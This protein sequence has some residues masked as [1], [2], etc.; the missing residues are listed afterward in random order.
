MLKNR[1]VDDIKSGKVFDQYQGLNFLRLLGQIDGTLLSSI[2]K[3]LIKNDSILVKVINYCSSR[4]TA[5]TNTVIKT[6]YVNFERVNE[7]I[8]VDEAYH[9]IND[10]Y[11]N[12]EDFLLLPEDDQMSAIA[13]KLL[14]EDVGS[15]NVS[16]RPISEEVIKKTLEQMKK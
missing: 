2:K 12:T 11:I 10:D 3:N 1:A 8:N 7:F 14:K 16:E 9:R 6:R 13:F 4:G 15:E 5:V